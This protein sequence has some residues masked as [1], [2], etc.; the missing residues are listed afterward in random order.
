MGKLVNDS[1]LPGYAITVGYFMVKYYT[2]PQSFNID[3]S[4]SEYLTVTV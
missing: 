4:V 3:M 1:S 2:I